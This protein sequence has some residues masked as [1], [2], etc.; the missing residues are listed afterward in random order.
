MLEIWEFVLILVG[1][2][3]LVGIVAGIFFW[4]KH[5]DKKTENGSQK[6]LLENLPEEINLDDLYEAEE[7]EVGVP[8]QSHLNFNGVV[9]LKTFRR[10]SSVSDFRENSSIESTTRRTSILS[11]VALP[12]VD[13][14]PAPMILASNNDTYYADDRS[15]T[16]IRPP[17]YHTRM[18]YTHS[19]TGTE[20]TPVNTPSP[21][22]FRKALDINENSTRGLSRP[23]MGDPTPFSFFS[24][25]T[26][27][28]TQS[29]ESVQA[30]W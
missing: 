15:L 1:A 17:S 2:E 14:C 21:S 18:S 5:V 10:L 26:I 9:E 7:I 25:N 11:N 27:A 30:K 12:D 29:S 16:D 13:P 3:A 19:M 20:L 24:E 6:D 23:K 22:R 28:S 4:R 8:A